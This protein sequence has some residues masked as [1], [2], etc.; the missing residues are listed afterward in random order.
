MSQTVEIV[1]HYSREI[2]NERTLLKA[3][4]HLVGEVRELRD[5]IRNGNKGPDGIKGEVMD[6]MNCALDIL[7]MTHPDIGLNEIDALMEAKCR[8]WMLKYSGDTSEEDVE[9]A[10]AAT[11]MIADLG[12][13]G[14]PTDLLS[15]MTGLDENSVKCVVAGSL[16]AKPTR[17]R[18]GGLYPLLSS[19]F[20]AKHSRRYGPV[21]SLWSAQTASGNT[22]GELLSAKVVDLPAV[23][24]HMQFIA[25]AMER[26]RVDATNESGEASAKVG[27]G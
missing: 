9:A 15:D 17:D 26:N 14:V 27:K 6:I 18:I 8:K 19:V 12:K 10:Q 3:F 4:K 5:E 20:V 22:L 24:A 21:V 1:R 11:D 13:N 2:V 16:V 7:F 23:E 25:K